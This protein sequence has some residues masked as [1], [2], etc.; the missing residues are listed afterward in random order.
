[1]TSSSVKTPQAGGAREEATL[2]AM[3]QATARRLPNAPA[4]AR[5]VDGRFEPV[6]YGQLARDVHTLASGLHRLGVRAGDRVA[7][8]AENGVEWALADLA[9]LALGA[10]TT[11]IYPTLPEGQAAYILRDAGAG[12]AFVGDAAQ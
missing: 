3:F 11:P 12:F 5:K 6:T 9:V 1:M 4:L 7:I 8:L 10:A 2:N